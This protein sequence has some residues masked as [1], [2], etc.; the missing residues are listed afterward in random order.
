MR[1]ITHEENVARQT[2]K[3]REPRIPVHV[4]LD[5]IRSL[6]NVGSIFRTC[7]GVGI[8]KLWL[9]GITGF[10]P[11]NQ[12]HKTALG[13]EDQVDWEYVENI[14]SLIKRL[15]TEGFEIVALE[16]TQ[17]SIFHTKYIPQFPVAL[18]VGNEVE[19]VNQSVADGCDQSIEIEMAGLKN[20][21]N[22]SVAFGI[23]A[24]HLRVGYQ[25][26]SD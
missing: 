4:I 15:K 17:A 26:M 7:D 1:K 11:N 25:K 22:V 5:D 9:C 6:H 16:Q 12:I 19:G 18:V 2:E 23:V 14:E 21:L 20:S 10:P 24:Y 3:M 13:A 8:K